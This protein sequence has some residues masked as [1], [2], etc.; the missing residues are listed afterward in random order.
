M[1]NLFS[2]HSYD[3]IM[4]KNQICDLS[5]LD[6]YLKNVSLEVRDLIRQLLTKDPASRPTAVEALNHPWF[7]S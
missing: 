2:G 7:S 4:A 6:R 5:H 3:D 1:R